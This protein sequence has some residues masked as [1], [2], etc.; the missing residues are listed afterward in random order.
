MIYVAELGIASPDDFTQL[1]AINFIVGLVVGG[2]GTLSGAVIGGLVI[3]IVLAFMVGLIQMAA[4]LHSVTESPRPRV[5]LDLAP[6]AGRRKCARA[7]FGGFEVRRRKRRIRPLA[8]GRRLTIHELDGGVGHDNLLGGAGDDLLIGGPGN[9][10]V[11]RILHIHRAGTGP[12][13][14]ISSRP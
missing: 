3:A 1:V 10:D 12:P 6:R 7:G 13:A 8:R 9:D 2:V 5:V 14:P 11:V 4:G